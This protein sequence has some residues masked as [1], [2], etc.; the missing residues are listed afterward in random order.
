MTAAPSSTPTAAPARE[1]VPQ[2]AVWVVLPTYNEAAN[3]EPIVAEVRAELSGC[4]LEG[5]AVLIVDDGSPDGTGEIADRLAEKY[6]DVHVLHRARKDGLGPAYIAGFDH[7]L[8]HGAGFVFEMDADFSHDARDIP[9][10]LAAARSDA[11]LVLGSRY[12]AGGALRDW[13]PLR[14]LESR[15]GCWYARAVL[16]VPV[17]DLTGGY[18]CFR[19]ESL[20][21][22][23][24]GA[25]HS[26]GY[27][28]Q[29]E[30]TYRALL[31]G[32]KV[33]EVPITFRG[34]AAGSSKMTGRIALE[35][36]W[37]VPVLRL[38]LHG[39]RPPGAAP[40]AARSARFR[41]TSQGGLA[42]AAPG[43]RARE[44]RF[45]PD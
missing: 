31:R 4:T 16:G 40:F 12:V 7:A 9:Q 17:R 21:A 26:R 18:K 10:L 35:A 22:V 34:R 11:D 32:L 20:R 42:R 5:Y 19:G 43:E 3:L 36:A 29:I 27:A 28:F 8:A 44:D 33:A 38:L 23:D 6:R 2:G 39:R 15:M 14:R 45:W 1:P 13:G 41:Q 30:L 37:R 24:Y 25:M